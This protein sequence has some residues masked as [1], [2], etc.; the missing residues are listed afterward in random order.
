MLHVPEVKVGGICLHGHFRMAFRG[1]PGGGIGQTLGKR[2]VSLF[3]PH[4]NLL[5]SIVLLEHS[6]GCGILVYGGV[7]LFDQRS[8]KELTCCQHCASPPPFAFERG[9]SHGS[10]TRDNIVMFNG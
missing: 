7:T 2:S 8:N 10:E 5:Y 3:E 9:M 1:L 4:K 6:R